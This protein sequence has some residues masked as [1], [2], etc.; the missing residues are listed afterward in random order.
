[1]VFPR[2][3]MKICKGAQALE[4]NTAYGVKFLLK[5]SLTELTNYII[6]HFQIYYDIIC[7]HALLTPPCKPISLVPAQDPDTE[8]DTV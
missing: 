8:G 7:M 3:F 2:K 1:M 6:R 5:A 4:K